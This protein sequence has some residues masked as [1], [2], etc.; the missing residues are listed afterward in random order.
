MQVRCKLCEFC[1]CTLLLTLLFV[2]ADLAI[3]FIEVSA[4][5]VILGLNVLE[6]LLA[7]VEV[8]FPASRVVTS[9]AKFQT[10]RNKLDGGEGEYDA[11]NY[12][13]LITTSVLL[14]VRKNDLQF[15]NYGCHLRVVSHLP[16][17]ISCLICICYS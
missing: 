12:S 5:L 6:V 16:R 1:A 15:L 13:D 8:M 2:S 3:V 4:H 10:Y 17:L 9:V 7:C 11:C 14:S